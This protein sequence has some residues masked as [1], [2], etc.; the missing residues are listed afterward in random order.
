[1]DG[2]SKSERMDVEEKG[3]ENGADNGESSSEYFQSYENFDVSISMTV[4]K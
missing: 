1:M 2:M 4:S 3:I